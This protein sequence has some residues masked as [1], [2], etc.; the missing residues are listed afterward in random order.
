MGLTTFKN[1]PDGRI[2]KLDTGIAKNHLEEKEIKQLE[3]TISA[4]FDYIEN[5]VERRNTFTMEALA[6]SVNKFL[7]FN[8]YKGLEGLGTIS[9]QEAINK[10]SNEYDSFNKTQKINSDF[11]KH[12]KT[13]RHKK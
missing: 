3:R 13:L 10:A 6:E 2:L 12:I 11:D 4:Y 8:E 9:H 5:L 1:A 7:S